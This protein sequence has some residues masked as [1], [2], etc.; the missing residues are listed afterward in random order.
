M[1]KR[2]VHVTVKDTEGSQI[3][4]AGGSVGQGGNTLS[5]GETE[6]R[7]ELEKV[8]NAQITTAGSDVM[9]VQALNDALEQILSALSPKLTDQQVADL[10]EIA[11]DLRAA[12]EKPP[13]ERN[14][15][16]IERLLASIGQYIGLAGLAATQAQQVMALVDK[17]KTMLGIG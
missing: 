2:T 1:S 8:R 16:K 6:V 15:S 17:V 3:T 12:L 4:T 13:A 5:A 14:A 7:V 10:Q 9:A 11:E